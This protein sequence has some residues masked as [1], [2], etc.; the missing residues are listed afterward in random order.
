MAEAEG[1]VI[2]ARLEGGIRNKAARGELRRGLPVG[3]LWGEKDGEV[4]LHPD[5]AVKGA[6]TTVFEKFAEVG[7]ARQVWL[8]FRSEGLRFPLQSPGVSE[9][10]WV[11]PTYVA[12]HHVLTNPVYAGA[13]VYGKTRQERYVDEAGQLRETTAPAATLGVAGP[14]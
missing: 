8:H 11:I 10:R 9:I 13:Y 6:L 3:F 7:S 14:A 5:Q 1:H 2:R 4:R 12:I